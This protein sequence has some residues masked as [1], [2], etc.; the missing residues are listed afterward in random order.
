M[1]GN[2]SGKTT[3]G[4]LLAGIIKPQSGQIKLNGSESNGNS[5]IVGFLFQDPDNGLV[6]TTVE[7]EVAFALENQN[8][9]PI[10]MN[11]IVNATLNSFHLENFRQRLV[12][13]LSGGEKQRL[14]LA[15]LIASKP[16]ILFLDEPAS[17]LDYTGAQLL[18]RTLEEITQANPDIIVLRVTQFARVAEKYKRIL[19]IGKGSILRDSSPEEIFSDS[20]FIESNHISP[21]LKYLTHHMAEA[22]K[23]KETIANNRQET[24]LELQNVNYSYDKEANN[25]VVFDL[26]LSVFRGEIVTLMGSSGA[27]KS[28]IAQVICGLLGPESG[29]VSFSDSNIK[30]VMCFQ[31]PERQFYLETVYDEVAYG[32]KVKVASDAL[33]KARVRESLEFAGLDYSVFKNRDPHSLSGGEARKLAFAIILALDADV[34]I[35]DEPTCGLDD[36]G[37]F[38]FIEMVRNLKQLAKAVVIISHNSDVIGEV[39]ERIIYLKDGRVDYEGGLIEFF[40]M[41]KYKE[42]VDIPAVIQYQIENCESVITSRMSDMLK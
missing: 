30:A 37:V 34:L 1:G 31:Q 13:Q 8:M 42:T 23:K 3:L 33:V 38:G 19:I 18:N 9:N 15:G 21:P 35:F 32:V 6:A 24:I 27:G 39:S 41:D 25:R 28:T 22:P 40:T 5:P 10:L 16:D 14:S 12:W 20:E 7:R 36:E 17:Y 2:G 11:E 4:M 29:E 26:S